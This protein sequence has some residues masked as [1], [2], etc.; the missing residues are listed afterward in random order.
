MHPRCILSHT[1][2]GQMYW[3]AIC[4]KSLSF[5][6]IVT[7][8]AFLFACDTGPT[9]AEFRGS[10][11]GT[12]YSV[13]VVELPRSIHSDTL[14]AEIKAVLDRV[15]EQMS[16]YLKDSELSR[17]NASRETDWLDA[18]PELVALVQKAREVSEL[19]GGAFDVTVGPLVNLWGFGPELGLEEPP[20]TEAIASTRKRVGYSKLHTRDEPPGLRKSIA[21]LY[22]DLSAIAKGYA[23]DRIA[24][25]LERRGILNYLVE[26]GGEIRGKGHNAH[27]TPWKIAIEKPVP[28]VREIHHVIGVDGVSVA[29]SG[30]YRN[31]FE[32]D[33][34]RYSHTI[35]PETGSPVTHAL[36]SVTVVNPSA[37][38]A[39]AL[40][41]GLMVLGPESYALAEREGLAVLFVVKTEGDFVSRPTPAFEHYRAE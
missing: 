10:T 31:Y 4:R 38:Y 19:T 32:R 11:M 24:E 40:A 8:C 35:D 21:D 7:S 27:G 2:A 13:K 23:V 41:T 25:Y 36:A 26:V 14:H 9:L 30:D 3:L 5:L 6:G 1:P 16:T 18:S 28:G 12:T 29:T 37:T 15:N 33:G 20:P 34:R 39:D 17:F 22:V